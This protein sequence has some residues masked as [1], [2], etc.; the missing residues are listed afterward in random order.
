MDWSITAVPYRAKARSLRPRR[1][2]F[3]PAG[4]ALESNLTERT[5]PT[6]MGLETQRAAPVEPP[7]TAPGS[8][9][10]ITTSVYRHSRPLR[11]GTLNIRAERLRRKSR[12]PSSRPSDPGLDPGEREPGSIT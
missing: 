1:S 7:G 5:G 9:R 2:C 11:D 8:D 10:F 6:A 4:A 3:G 12:T